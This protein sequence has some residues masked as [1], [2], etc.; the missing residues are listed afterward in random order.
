M[1]E[2]TEE[3][4]VET[5]STE[6]ASSQ[7]DDFASA[8]DALLE[9]ADAPMEEY[10]ANDKSSNK[11]DKSSKPKKDNSS[12]DDDSGTDDSG[13]GDDAVTDDQVEEAVRAGFTM[14]EVR[15]FTGTQLKTVL[16]RVKRDSKDDSDPDGGKGEEEE[17]YSLDDLALDPEEV[18]P[19][20][21]DKHNK[22][23]AFHKK[24]EEKQ[25]K[26]QH[27]RV[28]KE[29]NTKMKNAFLDLGKDDVFQD[30]IGDG[31]VENMDPKSNTAK[32]IHR[33]A[34]TMVV[35]ARGYQNRG[36]ELPSYEVLARKAGY[37]EFGDKLTKSG[38]KRTRN[39]IM[40]QARDRAGQ[41]TNPPNAKSKA[42]SSKAVTADDRAKTFI[43]DFMR[44][45]EG[46][47]EDGYDDGD[48]GL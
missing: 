3:S 12:A 23:L 29:T 35:I 22:L 7:T 19:D 30:V 6:D 43:K 17:E 21:A 32:A 31:D 39:K 10:E 16:A 4:V 11:P 1:A 40:D 42:T 41:F 2:P 44:D 37:A 47:M 27:E 20:V 18:D 38:S 5:V 34:D 8:E 24:K 9:E 25:A 45:N 46:G 14:H 36:E 28:L 15:G 13:D 26:E 33:I 48:D